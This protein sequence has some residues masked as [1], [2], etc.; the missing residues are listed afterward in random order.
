MDSKH[1]DV[2][3]EFYDSPK[4]P[5]ASQLVEALEQAGVTHLISLADNWTVRLH[6]LVASGKTSIELVHTCREGENV[7]IAAGLLTA[8]KKP[9]LMMQNSGFHESLD[10]VRLGIQFGLPLVTLIGY[11]GWRHGSPDIRGRF[12]EPVLRAFDIPY[13]VVDDAKKVGAVGRAI[14]LAEQRQGPTALLLP[15]VGGPSVDEDERPGADGQARMDYL[16]S[17]RCLG[18]RRT[19]EIVITHETADR[20]WPLVSKRED[21]DV[22]GLGCMSKVCSLGLGI[23]MAH[24]NRKV[25]V[26]DGDGSLVMNL[27]SLAT[28]ADVRPR[29]LVHF[30]L[31]NFEYEITAK[32]PFP[33]ADSID[34][35][36]IARGSGFPRAFTFDDVAELERGLPE[37]V[38]GE[39]LTFVSLKV[40]PADKQAGRHRELLPEGLKMLRR[41]LAAT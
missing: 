26:L 22:V 36:T 28:E 38:S 16:Q 21:L 32:Q 17:L 24:P 40:R 13:E 4:A 20:V 29:N 14:E 7:P 2:K 37:V 10:S 39:D 41:T 25:W 6:E 19:D 30:V 3:E 34:F 9:V 31:Q 11:R 15:G 35:A 18:S 12:T 8:G 1:T 33:M 5:K 23:A 27:G